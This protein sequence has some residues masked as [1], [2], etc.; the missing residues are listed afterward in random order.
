MATDQQTTATL[1]PTVVILPLPADGAGQLAEPRYAHGQVGPCQRCGLSVLSHF[2][3]LGAFIGCTQP[4]PDGYV[5]VL[6]ALPLNMPVGRSVREEKRRATPARVAKP[7]DRV[8][9]KVVKTATPPGRAKRRFNKARYFLAV[10]AGTQLGALTSSES[11]LKILKAFR[12]AGEAGLASREII[13]KT[14][15][16]HGAVQDAL[17]WMRNHTY[18]DVRED[19]TPES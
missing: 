19:D 14:G 13:E 1:T 5:F 15:L 18:V 17:S 3:K 2:D 16:P 7:A 10:P 12:S 4:V 11:R 8:N 6:V 9:G